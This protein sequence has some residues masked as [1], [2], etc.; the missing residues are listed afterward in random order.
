MISLCNMNFFSSK[1]AAERYAKGRPNVQAAAIKSFK[2]FAKITRPF[3]KCLDVGCGTGLS[4]IAIADLCESV[5][6]IDMSDAMLAIAAKHPKIKYQKA[7][8]ENLPFGNMT[9]DLI[10]VGL[11]M[12]W[13]DQI[14][15]L[16]EA[17]RVL[18]PNG[19]LVIYNNE[20][21]PEL[22]NDP[23]FLYWYNNSYLIRYPNPPRKNAIQF[24]ETRASQGFDFLGKAV[25]KNDIE[26]TQEQLVAYLTSQSNIIA[27]VEQGGERIKEVEK[28]LYN[29]TQE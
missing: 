9:F 3:K 17:A 23:E 2:E 16:K 1:S 13:F 18:L 19:W 5:F 26:M 8:A 6:G 10:T 22:I 11:A 20:F 28:W 24:D 4:S 21:K 12:H 27:K 25:F 15:F 14:K 7:N 29:S